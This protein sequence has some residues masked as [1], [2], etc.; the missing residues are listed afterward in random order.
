MVQ[1]VFSI[2]TLKTDLEL[3]L[4]IF[5]LLFKFVSSTVRKC[6]LV[7]PGYKEISTDSVE[8]ITFEIRELTTLLAALTS[9]TPTTTK[10]DSQAI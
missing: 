2:T 8:K 9:P 6:N 10:L 7:F 3:L 5:F 4:V 1:S